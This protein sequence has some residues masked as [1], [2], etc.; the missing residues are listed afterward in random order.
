[1]ATHVGTSLAEGQSTNR[2]PLF[3]GSNYTYWK[4]RMKI[5]IQ[6]LDYDMWSIIVNGPHTPTKIIDGEESTKSER[7]WDEVDKKLAQLNAKAMNVLY[8]SLD[9]NEFN[10][11]ST[12]ASAK[13][14]WDRLEVTHE[15]TNQVKESKINMLVHKYELFKMEH[16][17]SITAMFT[18]FT[19]IINGLKSLGKSYTNSELVRK[20]L[21][22]LSRTRSFFQS[23]RNSA[24]AATTPRLASSVP[25]VIR[26]ALGRPYA[27]T[28]LRIYP[29]RARYSSAASAVCFPSSRK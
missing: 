24:S 23:F 11:I 15:G 17:E 12:C 18:R 25:I 22:S 7:E 3:N 16:D 13:E 2:P 20:I 1:M 5:F 6:A 28:R 29:R 21:R 14:I 8:C 9:A 10:R 4:A 27:A 19:D 26:S